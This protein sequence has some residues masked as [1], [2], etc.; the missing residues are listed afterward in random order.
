MATCDGKDL[1]VSS[2]MFSLVSYTVFARGL[3]VH[4]ATTETKQKRLVATVFANSSIVYSDKF[5]LDVG[6][7][8]VQSLPE[9]IIR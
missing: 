5:D 6:A 1:L 9:Q 8:N 7:D 3:H 4:L 2:M